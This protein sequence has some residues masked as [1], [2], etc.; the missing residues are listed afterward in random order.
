MCKATQRCLRK[1]CN[2]ERVHQLTD[3]SPDT[4][5]FSVLS[6]QTVLDSVTLCWTEDELV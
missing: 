6:T 5:L 1:I 3:K 4:E 2:E